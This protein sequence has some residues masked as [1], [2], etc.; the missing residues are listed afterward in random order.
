MAQEI[1]I[2]LLLAGAAGLLAPARAG[3]RIDR[4]AKWVRRTAVLVI[5]M[6][7]A[8]AATLAVTSP[9]TLLEGL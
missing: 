3:S 9:K 4:W 6:T 8:A 2:T 5:V 1:L 7:L